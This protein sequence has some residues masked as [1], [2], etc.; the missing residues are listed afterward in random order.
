M[1]SHNRGS[2]LLRFVVPFFDPELAQRR[3][4][5]QKC[6]AS[7]FL[8][9]GLT[10]TWRFDVYHFVEDRGF[11]VWFIDRQMDTSLEDIAER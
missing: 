5:P 1:L 7:E 6:D 10:M 11:N 3:R 8:P 2:G 4:F 9:K